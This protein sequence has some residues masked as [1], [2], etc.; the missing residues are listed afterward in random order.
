MGLL[1]A[2][3]TL[4]SFVGILWG[5]SGAFDFSFNGGRFEIP[6]FM[7]WMA[8]AVLR[9]RQRADPTSSAAR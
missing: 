4:A 5:L 8:G 1:N 3:V 2:V 6:G 7:V 9:G